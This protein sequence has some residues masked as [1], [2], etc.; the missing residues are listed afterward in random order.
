MQQPKVGSMAIS[1]Q[2]V[3]D[4]PAIDYAMVTLLVCI[5]GNN[6]LSSI[7]NIRILLISTLLSFCG[8]LCLRQVFCVS[9]RLIVVMVGFGILFLFHWYQFNFLPIQTICGFYVK[10]LIAFIGCC[11]IK[12]FCRKLID[13]FFCI[14]IVSLIF[15]FGEQL[16]NLF[17]VDLRAVFQPVAD[18]L[19]SERGLHIGIYNFFAVRRNSGIFWEPGGFSGYLLISLILL[20]FEKERYNSKGFWIRFWVLFTGVLTTYSTTGYIVLPFLVFLYYQF[21]EN[22]GTKKNAFINFSKLLFLCIL[23]ESAF[24]ISYY[25]TFN[26]PGDPAYNTGKYHKV[27][28]DFV[29]EKI[30]RQYNYAKNTQRSLKHQSRFDDIIDDLSYIEQRPFTGWGIHKKTRYRL[31]PTN[32]YESGHGCGLTDFWCKFGIWGMT[33]LVICMLVSF[34]KIS[35]WSYFTACFSVFLILLISAGENF[36]RF[37]LYYSLFFLGISIRKFEKKSFE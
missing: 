17:N 27:H 32:V 3:S 29:F 23:L 14:C 33:I 16:F 8:V 21:H 1:K 4:H 35:N 9:K 37:P 24:F 7:T 10:L 6:L 28:G 26:E 31:H 19:G 13:V 11:I 15:F 30:K 36:I 34:L 5:S 18:F 22:K 25:L 20:S 12:D 2:S